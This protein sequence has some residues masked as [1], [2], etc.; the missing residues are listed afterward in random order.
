VRRLISI[1]LFSL[2]LSSGANAAHAEGA[3]SNANTPKLALHKTELWL[4]VAEPK[5]SIADID[6]GMGVASALQERLT[7]LN[8]EVGAVTSRRRTLLVQA[9]A[10]RQ[11]AA[12]LKS[13]PTGES[14]IRR[15]GSEA[16]AAELEQR[17]AMLE[18][19]AETQY[20]TML[21]L[22]DEERGLMDVTGRMRGV[23]DTIETST[24]ADAKQKQKA[25]TLATRTIKL[26]QLHAAIMM[27]VMAASQPTSS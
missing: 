27:T 7:M 1:A 20:E 4:A 8:T 26:F 13:A 25:A 17:A 3:Q 19:Q 12:D 14:G 5:P 23:V 18:A 11:K 6:A 21:R 10:C 24:I 2:A 9:A 22:S 15:A 16:K